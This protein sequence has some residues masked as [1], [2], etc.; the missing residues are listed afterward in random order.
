MPLNNTNYHLLLA[1]YDGTLVQSLHMPKKV[2]QNLPYSTAM[3]NLCHDPMA[4]CASRAWGS[5]YA[6][7]PMLPHEL[8]PGLRLLLIR[9]QFHMMRR[10]L[11]G[12]WWFT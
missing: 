6:L 12:E 3:S 11:G 5:V 8:R 2:R 10:A 4:W 7:E 9:E 1:L